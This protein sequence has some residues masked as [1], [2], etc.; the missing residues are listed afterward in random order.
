MKYRYEEFTWPEIRGAVAENRVAVLPVGTVEQHGPHLPLVTD[1]LTAT[2][3]SRLAVERIP[4]EAVL[5]PAVYYA[6]NEHH[7]DFPGTIAVEGTTFL[8]YVTDIG[9]S[10]AHHGFRKILL[11][12]GH[13][14]NVPFLD[15]AARNITNRTDA[16]CAMVPWWNLVPRELLEELRESAY[17][18]G[19]AHGCELETSV[20]LYLRGDL[21]QFEK[22]EADFPPQRSEFFYWDLQSPSPVFFQEFFSRYSRTGTSGDPTKA[23]AEKGRRFVEGAVERMVRLIGE[24]REREIR[25][26]VDHH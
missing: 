23:T 16:V 24:L 4:H 21:V 19:M 9:R 1:V 2:E 22:A 25:P 10:L 18:G 13:G 3:I 14:S 15:I 7:L 17:P 20:L 8:N 5:M 12:N 6:F 11:V 26:R